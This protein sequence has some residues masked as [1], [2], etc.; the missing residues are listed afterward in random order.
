MVVVGAWQGHSLPTPSETHQ[1]LTNPTAPPG[2]GPS[3]AGRQELGAWP[4]ARVGSLV[5]SLRT[6]THLSVRLRCLLP[7]QQRGM[8][9]AC[10]LPPSADAP[11]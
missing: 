8:G 1:R 7:T 5:P 3:P 6:E 9:N 11:Q 2:P 4:G 10:K